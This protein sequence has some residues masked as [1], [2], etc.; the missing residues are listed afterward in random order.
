M[1]RKLKRRRE[2]KTDYHQRLA[3]LKS[4]LP[5]LVVRKSNRYIRVQLVEYDPKSD[6][7]IFTVLSKKLRD[8][9][10]GYSFANTPA[11]Y[12]TGLLA[13]F[14][15]RKKGY[16]KAVLDIGLQRSTKGNRIYAV[17][18]GCVDAGLE[19]PHGTE[20]IPSEDRIR[21]EHI[22]AYAKL[23]KEKDRKLYERQFSGYL[24]QNILPEAMPEVFDQVKQR[25]IEEFGGKDAGS[26]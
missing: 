25:I 20:V 23:L 11:A 5:R 22:A 24:K 3:L 2:K 10:W 15:A 8:Y 7:I 17:V 9:G 19:V 4:G 6:K 21:G 1:F 13:G 14:I 16:G 18:K 26:E 12:L